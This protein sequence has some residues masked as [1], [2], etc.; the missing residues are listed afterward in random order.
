MGTRFIYLIRHGQ[1]TNL[2]Y[3]IPIQFEWQEWK[4][5]MFGV[6]GGLSEKGLEQAKLTAK[7]MS[8]YEI[9]NIYSSS[10]PRAIET[11]KY[12]KDAFPTLNIPIQKVEELFECYPWTHDDS[13][14][15]HRDHVDKAFE[16][17]VKPYNEDGF[18]R[19]VLVCHGN[20]ISYLVTKVLGLEPDSGR[21]FEINNCSLSVIKIDN[22]GNMILRALNDHG[23]LDNGILPFDLLT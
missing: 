13:V 21:K 20:V 19:D 1:Y 3:N 16:R 6:D 4:K 23:H 2:D 15:I 7:R 8:M 12:I 5:L 11:A 17:F 22:D 14:T 10:L 9:N 18:M